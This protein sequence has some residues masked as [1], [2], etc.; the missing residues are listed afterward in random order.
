[1]LIL[2]RSFSARFPASRS[3]SPP[4]VEMSTELEARVTR[5]EDG[6]SEWN[7]TTR[8]R[9][10]GLTALEKRMCDLFKS[11][12]GMWQVKAELYELVLHD[13]DAPLGCMEDIA[14]QTQIRSELRG[15]LTSAEE[16]IGVFP[17]G[18]EWGKHTAIDIRFRPSLI[19]LRFSDLV[20]STLRPFLK[21]LNGPIMCWVPLSQG[22]MTMTAPKV[23]AR[24][25]A[26]GGVPRDPLS[27]SAAVPQGAD[28]KSLS[29][30]DF[31]LAAPPPPPPLLIAFSM[32]GL[33]S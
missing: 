12:S 26:E 16:I 25:R 18:G 23:R 24:V 33:C 32:A 2:F 21:Q 7:A 13:L 19:A 5:I 20:R 14:R 17:S 9:W 15:L 29:L 31:L 1:M 8:T 30:L 3:P 10:E 28:A 6:L 27:G 4:R 22:E 11:K